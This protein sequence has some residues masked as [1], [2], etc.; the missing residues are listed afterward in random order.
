MVSEEQVT[1]DGSIPRHRRRG[2]GGRRWWAGGSEVAATPSLAWKH[3]GGD[4]DGG[5]V[6]TVS[7]RKL[8]ASLWRQLSAMTNGGASVRRQCGLSFDRLGFE[9]CSLAPIPKF[10]AEGVTKWD[11]CNS[12]E[13]DD[14]FESSTA[15]TT[16]ADSYK[17]R[18]HVDENEPDG[19]RSRTKNEQRCSEFKNLAGG[20]KRE[21][22]NCR[23][24]D[25]VNPKL[26]RDIAEAKSSA[27]MFVQNLEREKK[28][29]EDLEDV[30]ENLAKEIEGSKA[31]IEALMN[32]QKRIE[33]EVEEERKM[34]QLAEVWREER[35]QMKMADARLILEDKYAEISNLI[36]DLEA[37]LRRLNLTED[38][39]FDSVNI[40]RVKNSTRKLPKSSNR[41]AVIKDSQFTEAERI[42]D[43]H[44]H[45]GSHNSEACK[46]SA[47]S[48]NQSKKRGSSASKIQRAWSKS[49]DTCKNILT[50]GSSDRSVPSTVYMASK[51]EK[52][53]H[54]VRAMKGDIEW[55]AR[56]VPRSSSSANRLK[57]TLE[58]QKTLLR[59]VLKQRN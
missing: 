41:V 21:S 23:N 36:A 5:T 19:G 49:K 47:V 59:N 40:Q 29:R 7:A 16:E 50:D 13:W 33:M 22:K 53:P 10:A 45:N 27:M 56:G 15:C 4:S 8:A 6:A 14:H 34:L 52:N 11:Y 58:S 38:E 31:Q 42:D 55:P 35:L 57:A 46:I 30:C 39:E 25:M 24:M 48:L 2:I 18:K 17:A 32:Q 20:A 12:K 51:V 26:L 9:F 3:R 44:D 43:H 54:V 28:A 37:L 1:G